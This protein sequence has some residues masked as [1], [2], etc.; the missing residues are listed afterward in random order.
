MVEYDQSVWFPGRGPHSE[1]NKLL[2]SRINVLYRLNS[3]QL[4]R[5]FF[6][7]LF[8]SFLLTLPFHV[9]FK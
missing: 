9:I 5:P 3:S 2:C 7:F 1:L 8:F 4:Y 6:F